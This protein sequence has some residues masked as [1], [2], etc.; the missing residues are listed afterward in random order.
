[1][2]FTDGTTNTAAAINMMRNTA[3][4]G[5]NGDRTGVPNVGVVLTDGKWV[6][7]ER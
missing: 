4:Q 1:M 3:F 2:Y 7:T 5:A 6:V